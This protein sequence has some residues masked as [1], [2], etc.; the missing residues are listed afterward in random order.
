MIK[1]TF[2]SLW[3]EILA[4]VAIVAL[5]GGA[6]LL[7]RS[8]GKLLPAE[9]APVP[10]VTAIT[11]ITVKRECSKVEVI[12]GD[13]AKGN[14]CSA[15]GEI[16]FVDARDPVQ[17]ALAEAIATQEG[18]YAPY[19]KI[20]NEGR[21]CST[22]GI[23]DFSG[24][25]CFDGT[26]QKMEDVHGPNLPQQLH[27]PGALSFAGQ[28]GATRDKSGYA[29]FQTDEAGWQALHRDIAAKWREAEKGAWNNC[30]F[31]NRDN[32]KDPYNGTPCE[33]SETVWKISYNW[34]NG[35]RETY[36]KNVIEILRR[37]GVL[38]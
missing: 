22:E 33:P 7:I 36:A 12:R 20:T 37:K 19:T 4:L 38:K 14:L 34:S 3:Q 1:H 6:G 5:L 25:V 24:I 16:I 28:P 21:A 10:A 26:V 8:R 27:N 15:D 13:G 18:F 32:A 30:V 11:G 31:Y 17:V 35:D 9:D 29:Q 2:L 23:K